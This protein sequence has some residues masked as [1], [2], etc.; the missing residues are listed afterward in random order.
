MKNLVFFFEM[1]QPRRLKQR[2][3]RV[4]PYEGR[5]EDVY[6]DECLNKEVLGRA[7][8]N[9]Y[10][11]GLENILR[12][13]EEYGFK[14]ALGV[15][16]VF[17]EQCSW[18]EPKVIELIRECV[19]S[20]ACEL[21]GETY[22]H[23]LASIINFEEFK[24]QVNAQK[25]AVKELFGADPIVAENTEF[26]YNNEIAKVLKG[27]EFKVI[28]TEGTERV[29]GWRSPNYLYKSKGSDVFLLTRNYRLS[30]DIGFR[31]TL[32]E[33]DGWPLTAEK[34]VEWLSKT[35]GDLIFIAMDFETM[36]EHHWPESG[37]HDFIRAIPKEVKNYNDLRFSTPSEVAA[38]LDAVDEL[39]VQDTISWADLERDLSAWLGNDLQRHCF[40]VV[41]YLEP[42]AKSVGGSF[43]RIWRYFT[44]SDYYHY[45]STKGGGAGAVHSYFSHFNS[46][47][48]AFLGFAWILTDFRYRLY[49]AMGEKAIYYRM[50][51]GDLPDSHAFHFYSGFAKP[52]GLKVK[53]LTELRKTIERIDEGSLRF[54]IAR[55]DLS[56]WVGEILGCKGLSEELLALKDLPEGLK[57][58]VIKAVE[59]A[60][61][62]AS[63]LLF[64]GE[65]SE[66]EKVQ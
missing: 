63:A 45:M 24:E 42:M 65:R 29:L 12:A 43:L 50:L 41:K 2:F 8:K 14:F 13:A 34:Y 37:I 31:F 58:G 44:T 60:I 46:P 9:C 53:N 56:R 49:G 39:D 55:G 32:R 3:G 21:V 18:W 6:F 25:R 47:I 30:D 19:D 33:W 57:E 11:P 59:G 35:P 51:F 27:L 62:E 4:L 15:S 16:G 52:L 7:S 20:G 48:E 64:G 22:Y 10:I 23:S 17:L 66:D 28:L 54:H 38:E 1:H 5:V 40:E 36:G 61:K 26:I